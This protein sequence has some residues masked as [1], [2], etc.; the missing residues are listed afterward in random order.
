MRMVIQNPYLQRA[1]H[2]NLLKA[3]KLGW[4]YHTDTSFPR[5]GGYLRN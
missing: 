4:R 3:P 5:W 2:S 1:Y